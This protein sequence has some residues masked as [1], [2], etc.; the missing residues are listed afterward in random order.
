MAPAVAD[1]GRDPAVRGRPF[2]EC[3]NVD[4]VSDDIGRGAV[5]SNAADSRLC[6]LLVFVAAKCTSSNSK[7]RVCTSRGAVDR[8]IANGVNGGG[9]SA[10]RAATEPLDT[11]R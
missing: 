8:G 1:V 2:A 7:A 6:V 5:A 4:V 11:A 9:T 10:T 3:P